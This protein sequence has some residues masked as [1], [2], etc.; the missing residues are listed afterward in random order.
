MLNEGGYTKQSPWWD[1]PGGASGKESVCQ[2]RRPGLVPG[3]GRSPGEGNEV[4]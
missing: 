4:T 2:C 3:S 1:F